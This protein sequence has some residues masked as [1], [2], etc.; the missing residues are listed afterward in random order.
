MSD[1]RCIHILYDYTNILTVSELFDSVAQDF[2]SKIQSP[3]HFSFCVTRGENLESSITPSRT[4]VPA[5]HVCL[6]AFLNVLLSTI[7]FLS[8]SSS[9][10]CFMHLHLFYAIK[11]SLLSILTYLRLAVSRPY[12]HVFCSKR[13]LK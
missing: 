8:L 13:Q 12:V 4:S 5:S 10:L 2:F 3:D 6:K 11:I 7:V 1:N 9:Q